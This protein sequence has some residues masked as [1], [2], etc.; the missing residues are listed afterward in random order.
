MSQKTDLS[1]LKKIDTLI[2]K[3]DVVAMVIAS[4]PNGEQVT[5]LLKNKTQKEQIRILREYNLPTEIIALMI[6]TTLGTVTHSSFF[7]SFSL[8]ALVIGSVCANNKKR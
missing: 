8:L 4:K 2:E 5:N 1:L 3:L 6:G 7:S